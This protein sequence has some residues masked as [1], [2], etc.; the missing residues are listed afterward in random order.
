MRRTLIQLS[1]EDRE[2]LAS[3]RP[4]TLAQAQQLPGLSAA[5]LLRL[6]AIMKRRHKAA[7]H[8]ARAEV[9]YAAL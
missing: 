3:S 7:A 5:G 9:A 6:L 2:L 8:T 1:L 4:Q